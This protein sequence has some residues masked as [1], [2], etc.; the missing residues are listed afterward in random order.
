MVLWGV[1]LGLP[2]NLHIGIGGI[3]LGE[4]LFFL[5]LIILLNDRKFRENIFYTILKL[6]LFL[7][8]AALF[9]IIFSVGNFIGIFVFES[10]IR[11]VFILFRQVFYLFILIPVFA[12]LATE[13]TA[14]WYLTAFLLGVIVSVGINFYSW[15]AVGDSLSLPGQNPLG[16]QISAIF[17]FVLYCFF[18]GRAGF[19]KQLVNLLVLLILL[20]AALLTWSKAAWVSVLVSSAVLIAMLFFG[21]QSFNTKKRIAGFLIFALIIL[22]IKL[23]GIMEIVNTEISASTGSRSNEQR[24]LSAVSGIIIGTHYPA[25]VGGANYSSAVERLTIDVLWVMPDPH[26]SYAQVLSWAGILGFPLFLF[27]FF[28]PMWLVVRNRKILGEYGFVYI[29][30]LSGIYI[31]ANFSGEYL[32]Q[33]LS[34]SLFALITGH[35]LNKRKNNEDDQPFPSH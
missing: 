29:S 19:F 6:R 31:S 12:T 4:I 7:F 24:I 1:G 28:Y 33:P 26:N 15:H 21:A 34:W 30:I 5:Y 13:R 8:I 2:G 14:E 22:L 17:P 18:K 32:T 25:G 11:S 10:D 3:G 27:L 23:P 9:I 35:I 16:S 20:A